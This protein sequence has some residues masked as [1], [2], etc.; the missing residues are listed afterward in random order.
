MFKA[1]IDILLFVAAVVIGGN[2]FY[3]LLKLV[4]HWDL[5]IWI[6]CFTLVLLTLAFSV[7]LAL[8]NTGFMQ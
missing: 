2:S 5:T 3:R 6:I 4:K 8:R 7:T 1:V